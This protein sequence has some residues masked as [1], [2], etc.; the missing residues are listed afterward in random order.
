MRRLF[1]LLPFLL[2]ACS[3]GAVVFAPTP[4]PPDLSPLPYQHPGGVFSVAVPR[5]WSVYV[6]NTTAL[7]AAAFTAPGED[8]AALR[9]AVIN[10]GER[11]D[12]ASFG[13]LI[14]T[15]QREV[16]PD[17]GRY[18]EISRQAMGDGS[19]RLTGLR[20]DLGITQQINTFIQQ[21]GPFLG[22][23]EVLLPD[24][25][26][27]Q[28]EYETIVNTFAINAAA[29]LQTAEASAL[30]FATP[31]GLELLHV[32][33]WSTAS[34]VFF[35]TGEVANTSSSWVVD[36]PVRAVL[37]SADGLPVVEA[38][39]SV[40][41]HGIPPGG[42]AP[43][44]LR[45]GGGQPA[46]TTTY[47]LSLGGDG[48]TPSSEPVPFIQGDLTWTDESSVNA[49]GRLTITGTVLNSGSQTI[50]DIRAVVS[51]FD[52][53]QQVIAAGFADVSPGLPPGSASDYQIIV[54]EIGGQ[55]VNYILNVQ[56]LP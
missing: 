49:D 30:A 5:N 37:V 50:R 24:T 20:H 52:A 9:F 6:Q 14:D 41:G 35:I 25:P 42:F 17:A 45:F 23:I 26:A 3:G 11:L 55:P 16:R 18:S 54:P 12:S 28:S 48:W 2:A 40:M 10:L 51:V 13:A 53:A 39:D 32:A 22:I 56:G 19:W 31:G 43:F 34:G 4:P 1:L 33:A 8:E 46:L 47:Q 44:S 21:T 36:V 29:N 38:V 15:Y 27:R 7:A